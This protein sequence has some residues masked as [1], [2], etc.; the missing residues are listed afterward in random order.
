MGIVNVGARR[1]AARKR[2]ASGVRGVCIICQ[3]P[4]TNALVVSGKWFTDENGERRKAADSVYDRSCHRMM[5]KGLLNAG[6]D[7]PSTDST[8]KVCRGCNTVIEEG[9]KHAH[10][11][12]QPFHRECLF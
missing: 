6:H 3:K 9:D 4:T 5:R 1:R 12:G 7:R 8:G 10:R 11:Q 2:T